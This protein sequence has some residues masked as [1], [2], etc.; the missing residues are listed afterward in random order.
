MTL[1]INFGIHSISIGSKNLSY[2]I[3]YVGLYHDFSYLRQSIVLMREG[4]MPKLRKIS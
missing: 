3:F 2:G 1:D 4:W